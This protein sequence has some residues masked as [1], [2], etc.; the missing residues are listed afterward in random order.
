MTTDKTPPHGLNGAVIARVRYALGLMNRYLSDP[1]GDL[2]DMKRAREL[3][4]RVLDEVPDGH[5]SRS[6]FLGNLSITLAEHYRVHGDEP[7][8]RRAIVIREE[9]LGTAADDDPDRCVHE[10]ALASLLT[11]NISGR[12]RSELDQAVRLVRAATTQATSHPHFPEL[13][14]DIATV[15]LSHPEPDLDEVDRVTAAALTAAPTGQLSAV[16]LRAAR[17]ALH[18]ARYRASGA[19]GDLDAAITEGESAVAAVPPTGPL[20]VWLLMDLAGSRQTRWRRTGAAAD[21]DAAVDL[22]VQ[23]AATGPLRGQLPHLKTGLA[24]VLRDRF[25]RYG[26]PADIRN[27]V[28]AARAAV[29]ASVDHPATRARCLGNLSGVYRTR[30]EREQRPK[31][32]FRAV[33]SA[34]EAV[35]VAAVDDPQ[36]LRLLGTLTLALLREFGYRRDRRRIDEAVEV[37]RTAVHAAS[38]GAG[39]SVRPALLAN[40]ANALRARYEWTGDLADLDEAVALAQE[41]LDVSGGDHVGRARRMTVLATAR[42]RRF[43][44]VGRAEDIDEAVVGCTVALDRVPADHPQR[45]GLLANLGVALFRRFEEDGRESDLEDCLHACREAVGSTRDDD[46]E[47][48]RRLSLLA[49]AVRERFLRAGIE[50]DLVAAVAAAT[51]AVARNPDGETQFNLGMALRL[52]HER[53]ML[54]SGVSTVRAAALAAFTSCVDSTG[55]APLIRAAAAAYRAQLHAGHGEWQEADAS[56]SVALGLL[57]ELTGR[58]LGWDSR[59][60]QLGR[61]AHLGVDAAAVAVRLGDFDRAVAVLEASRGVLL[62]QAIEQRAGADEVRQAARGLTGLSRD[63]AL[64]LADE[65][66]RLSLLLNADTAASTE[67]DTDPVSMADPAAARRD[68]AARWERVVDRIRREVPGMARFRVSPPLDLST[69]NAVEGPIVVVNMSRFGCAALVVQASGTRL[70]PLPDLKHDDASRRAEKFNRSVTAPDGDTASAVRSTVDWLRQAVA[71][72][73]L[74]T[75][76]GASWRI[77]WMPTGVLSALPLHAAAASDPAHAHIVSS[78]TTTLRALIDAYANPTVYAADARAVVVAVSTTPGLPLPRATEEAAMVERALGGQ[79]EVL[80]DDSATRRAVSTALVEAATAHFCCHAIADPADPASGALVLS[81]GRLLLRDIAKLSGENRCLA[82]LSACSTLLT[83]GRLADEGM[84]IGSGFQFANF[85]TVIGTLW[86]VDDDI[87][88]DVAKAFYRLLRSHWEP[89][90][91]LHAAVGD[92]RK[93]YP[94]QP[95]LWGAFV[96][97]GR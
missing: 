8:L 63:T 58:R 89:A 40:A 30:Y 1:A 85:P 97:I 90:A 21:L 2:D 72:P 93:R 50:A 4:E 39:G 53:D 88:Y 56:Y 65:F 80:Q 47:A 76:G 83:G 35:A 84:H 62:R 10:V 36:R 55:T 73:V 49:V 51:A 82:Y 12:A 69:L 19:S 3:W 60:A 38:A 66:D 32:L 77:W 31:D 92:V 61:L 52:R 14:V 33:R 29:R 42:L 87:A 79:V 57:P 59:H 20:R 94:N 22:L 86:K 43:E 27:S 23:A 44:A 67:F 71:A 5:R 16:K 45:P 9:A 64:E 25:E 75:V 24:L 34:R 11:K 96:H 7:S 78:T 81:D 54:V 48:G 6:E 37:S 74:D 95:A 91:A 68:I 41:S 70:V 13:A 46:P 17:S 18:L 26:D 15:L 28:T